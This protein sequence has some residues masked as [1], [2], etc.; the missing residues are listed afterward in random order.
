VRDV[1]QV[2]GTYFIYGF[3]GAFFL[4]AGALKVIFDKTPMSAGGQR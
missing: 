2:L 4:Q 1:R 3:I